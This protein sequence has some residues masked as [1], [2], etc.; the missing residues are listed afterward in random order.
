MR[1]CVQA[2][3]VASVLTGN[4]DHGRK[5]IEK[6]VPEVCCLYRLPKYLLLDALST[7]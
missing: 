1:G 7:R 4:I 2:N 5:L 6:A 3:L